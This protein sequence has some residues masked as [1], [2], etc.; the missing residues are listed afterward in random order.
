MNFS[1]TFCPLNIVWASVIEDMRLSSYFLLLKIDIEM[2]WT[3]YN[4]IF[5]SSKVDTLLV[6]CILHY[7]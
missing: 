2:V 5:L 7:K 3:I 6:T 4:M 1:Q